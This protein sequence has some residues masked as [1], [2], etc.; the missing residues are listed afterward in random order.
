MAAEAE[1]LVDERPEWAPVVM[2][3]LDHNVDAPPRWRQILD[4]WVANVRAG[5]LW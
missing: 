1:H 2:E 4:T 5:Y 3:A